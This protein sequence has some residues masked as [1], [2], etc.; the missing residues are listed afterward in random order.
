MATAARP[1]S[2]MTLCVAGALSLTVAM[3]VGRFAFTPVL[4]LMIR[5]GSLDVASGGWIA[6]ANYVGY[7]TGALMAARLRL[8]ATQ[9]ALLGLFGTA[10][11]TAMMSFSQPWLWIVWRLL[12]GVASAWVFVATG[13][14]CLGALAQAGR[15]HW[16]GAV[17]AGVGIG[18]AIAGLHVWLAG[19]L[20]VGA[21]DLWLQLAL[22][23]LALGVPIWFALR[24][25]DAPA[26]PRATATNAS[27]GVSPGLVLSY[28]VMGFGYI[29]PATFLPVLARGVTDDPR[30]FGLAWPVFGAMAALST[31]LAGRWMQRRP[32]LEVWSACQ[33]LMGVGALL[34]T[35]WTHGIAIALSAVLVGG[36]F[37]VVTLAGVQEARARAADDPSRAIGRMTAAFAAGQIAGPVAAALLL[38]MPALRTNGIDIA[39]QAAAL[40][41]FATAWW[42]QREAR[43]RPVSFTEVSRAP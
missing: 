36:T 24:R 13:V 3:G 34:P 18:I 28:G 2:T 43:Q 8:R 38:R 33:A 11:L 10:V 31:L 22:L 37:M 14:W 6:A 15:S 32:R 23:T 19:L 39:L 12:A 40:A 35:L 20:G 42:L 17:Y 27:P 30:W 7:L 4:P 29:L 16:G 5:E 26:L 1:I 9:L 41:L 25:V 21:Q